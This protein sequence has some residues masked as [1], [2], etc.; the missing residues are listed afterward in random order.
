M[1]GKELY[2]LKVMYPEDYA[3]I[4]Q[5]EV[6]YQNTHMTPDSSTR[7]L[8]RGNTIDEKIAEFTERG[9]VRGNGGCDVCKVQ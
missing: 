7:G 6:A 5:M 2:N 3:R 1:S 4:R 9:I 8:C